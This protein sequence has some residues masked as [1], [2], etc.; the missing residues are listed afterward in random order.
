SIVRASDA[1][2]RKTAIALNSRK[3]ASCES[4]GCAAEGRSGKRSRSSGTSSAMSAASRPKWQASS[5]GVQAR[6]CVRSDHLNPRP[7]CGGPAVPPAP[8]PE[9]LDPASERV[10]SDR[11]CE[12]GLP[13]AGLAR[14]QEEP[15]VAVERGGDGRLH[16]LPLALATDED[17]LGARSRS[18]EPHAV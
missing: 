18:V 4:E 13:D 8:S 9:D 11:M 3:R 1:F 12:R 5:D 14:Q 2:R 10:S 17:T 16:V 6:A 15:P 7:I